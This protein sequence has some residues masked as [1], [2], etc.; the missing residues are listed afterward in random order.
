ME[1]E[2]GED[3]RRGISFSQRRSALIDDFAIRVV[4]TLLIYSSAFAWRGVA[5]RGMERH[6]GVVVRHRV[7]LRG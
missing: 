7:C 2:R 6:G 5:W 1:E 4:G 3:G